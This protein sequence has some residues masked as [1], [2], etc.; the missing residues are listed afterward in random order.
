M[1]SSCRTSA[2]STTS[3]TGTSISIRFATLL[4]KIKPHLYC[5]NL[6]GMTKGGEKILPIG[7]GE[8]DL[9]LLKTIRDS[10]YAGP[11]GILNHTDL[12]AEKRLKDNLDG[13]DRLLQQLAG[14][15]YWSVEDAAARA[16]LPMY[17]TIPAANVDDLTPANGWPTTSPAWHR[18]H[19]GDACMRY[20]PAGSDQ[21]DERQQIESRVGLSQRRRRRQHSM[22]SDHRRRR[23]VRSDAG[24][25]HRRGRCNKREREV[26]VQA[27]RERGHVAAR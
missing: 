19:G 3:I 5:L 23:A 22:Q 11:I 7:A 25:L 12:D 13:L 14:D 10:G 9:A 6:N 20:S 24:Q 1:R 17:Q 4:E 8:L 2:S 16:K 26:A 15:E 21:S 18:S 27:V